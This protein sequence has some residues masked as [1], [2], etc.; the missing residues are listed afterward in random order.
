MKEAMR[1]LLHHPSIWR[2][3][4]HPS[5]HYLATGIKALDQYLPGGG[6]PHGVTEIFFQQ[7]G[8]GELSLLLPALRD[9][10]QQGRYLFF[11]D[12][13]HQ[14]HAPALLQWQLDLS[15]L[16]ILQTHTQQD[17]YWA[18]EQCLRHPACAT[19]LAWPDKQDIKLL[20]RL[21][22]ATEKHHARAI[23]FYHDQVHST[24]HAS[25]RLQ[26]KTTTRGLW[27]ELLKSKG[28]WP[29]PPLFIPRS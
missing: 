11:I 14:L 25:L 16:L 9:S 22:L 27:V 10:I 13:P 1:Q 5:S 28:G 12:P 26:L 18:M 29:K 6:W 7:E 17:R 21:Q 2:G 20:R 23:L 19:L 8:M 3:Q 24:C 15:K 4:Q